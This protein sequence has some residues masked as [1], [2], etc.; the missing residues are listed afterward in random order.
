MRSC[1][2]SSSDRPGV[3]LVGAVT[4][5]VAMALGCASPMMPEGEA[6]P[7]AVASDVSELYRVGASDRLVVRVLPDPAIERSVVVRPDG[8]FSLDLI[9]DVQAAG[10][11]LR[12]I[13]DEIEVRMEEFRQSPSVSVSLEQ[14]LSN[15]VAVMGEVGTPTLFPLER[16][17]TQSEAI[18][19]AGGATQLAAASRVRVIRKSGVDE[20]LYL[21][22]LNEIQGGDAATDMLLQ[23]GD[24]VYVPPAA[25]VEAGYA[26][27]RFLFPL[28]Q[29]MQTVAGPLLGFL[30]R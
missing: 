28:E 10:K 21:A 30:I 2:V 15:A 22:D 18:A 8:Y 24:L 29:L 27:R 23:R 3:S 26:L 9:G 14:P 13:G 17:T 6:A 4:F 12:E 5:A 25:T 7:R 19:R 1:L 20:V 16:D 11:T